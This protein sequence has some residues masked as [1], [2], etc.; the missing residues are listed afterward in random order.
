MSPPYFDPVLGTTIPGRE[1]TMTSQPSCAGVSPM[2]GCYYDIDDQF[3]ANFGAQFFFL[4]P[5]GGASNFFGIKFGAVYKL[6]I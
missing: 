4:F 6:G 3:A 2:F 1:M 5:E